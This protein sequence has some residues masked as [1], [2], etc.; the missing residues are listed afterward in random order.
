[1]LR[2]KESGGKV[3]GGGLSGFP[4][5]G[6]EF[7]EAVHGVGADAVEDIAEVCER[8]DLE[9]FARRDE[10][11]EDGGGSPAVVAATMP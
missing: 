10:A 7:L 3:W 2:G 4:V 5:I 9:S 11:G 6:E 8:V 1:M